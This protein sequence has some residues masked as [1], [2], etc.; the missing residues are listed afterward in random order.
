MGAPIDAEAMRVGIGEAADRR[1][2]TRNSDPSN[3]ELVPNTEQDAMGSK[4]RNLE[5]Y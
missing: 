4:N 1:R 2:S 5:S 3:A